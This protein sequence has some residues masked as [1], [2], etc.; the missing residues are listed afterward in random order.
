MKVVFF[1]VLRE[2]L[3]CDEFEIENP[4]QKTV[5]QVIDF[6]KSQSAEWREVLENQEI[7]TAVNHEFVAPETSVTQGDEIALFPPVTG[8]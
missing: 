5:A 4:A 3:G 2:R 1:A 8:G 7:L 6:L